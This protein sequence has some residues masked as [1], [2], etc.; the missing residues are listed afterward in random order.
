MIPFSKFSC[1]LL[2]LQSSLV[3]NVSLEERIQ[4]MV[5]TEF[6]AELPEAFL[7]V[8]G[9]DPGKEDFFK[10][11]LRSVERA[12]NLQSL[13]LGLQN[14]VLI[15]DGLVRQAE[16]KVIAINQT[17]S[18]AELRLSHR[19]PKMKTELEDLNSLV[20]ERKRL[21]ERIENRLDEIR[22][23]AGFLEQW[24]EPKP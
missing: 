10:D 5:L 19:L 24:I 14:Q 16:E 4:E 23:L 1:F 15:F 7:F 11:H 21:L 13:V 2:L 12:W 20:W 8:I 18:E 6:G 9:S 3:G 22:F 17:L